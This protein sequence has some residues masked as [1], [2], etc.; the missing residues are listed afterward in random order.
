MQRSREIKVRKLQRHKIKWEQPYH[1]CRLPSKASTWCPPGS[2]WYSCSSSPAWLH[3]QQHQPKKWTF[4]TNSSNSGVHAV[5][6][7]CG[8]AF[9]LAEPHPSS[10]P[11]D[12]CAGG[13]SP[14]KYKEILCVHTISGRTV[15]PP[16]RH[17]HFCDVCKSDH[18]HEMAHWPVHFASFYRP[19]TGAMLNTL[20]SRATLTP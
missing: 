19:I 6:H 12:L 7:D 5:M 10:Y 15:R 18:S 11:K 9:I 17:V 4:K 20:C 3:K 13:Q 8:S 2:V 16:C 1:C 14:N